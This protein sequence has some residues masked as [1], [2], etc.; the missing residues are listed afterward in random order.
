MNEPVQ[1]GY[2]ALLPV[3]IACVILNTLAFSAGAAS[4]YARLAVSQSINAAAASNNARSC[5]Q[6]ALFYLGQDNAYRPDNEIV[7]L[8]PDR[9][10]RIEH[11]HVEGTEYAVTTSGISGTSYIREET[12]AT[13]NGAGMIILNRRNI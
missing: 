9:F 10:C 5:S 8:A 13:M 6:R 3:L 4:F 11:I 1:R 7:V 12:R 2:V